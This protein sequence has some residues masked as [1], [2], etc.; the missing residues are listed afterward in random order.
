MGFRIVIGEMEKS[1]TTVS[2]RIRWV[3]MILCPA[4]QPLNASTPIS[5]PFDVSKSK[6][7]ENGGGGPQDL[8]APALSSPVRNDRN[9]AGFVVEPLA[10]TRYSLYSSF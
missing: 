1:S 2:G 7:H 8:A 3:D 5:N 10:E 4:S 9:F 6:S